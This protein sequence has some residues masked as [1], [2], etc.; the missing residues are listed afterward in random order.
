MQR[1]RFGFG[2]AMVGV[3]LVMALLPSTA[4]QAAEPPKITE[5]V[6]TVGVDTLRGATVTGDRA[7]KSNHEQQG[8][9][10]GYLRESASHGRLLDTRAVKTAH[11]PDPV[12]P[13]RFVDL[14]WDGNSEPAAVRA[15][16]AR[17]GTVGE[18]KR[19]RVDFQPAAQTVSP[20]R[21]RRLALLGA[22]S[23][24]DV[25]NSAAGLRL[26][27]SGYGTFYFSPGYATADTNNDGVADSSQMNSSFEDWE[28][29]GSPYF[30]YNRFG[31]WKPA[32]PANCS[33]YTYCVHVGT[34]DF[35]ILSRPWSGYRANFKKMWQVTPAATA[36]TCD[37][38]ANFS[39]SAGGFTLGIPVHR[40]NTTWTHEDYTAMQFGLDWDGHTAEKLR[41]DAAA[42][43]EAINSWVPLYWADQTY[44]AVDWCDWAM[45]D[46]CSY[47]FWNSY[48]FQDSGW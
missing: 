2:T 38:I 44:A 22:G 5:T 6:A 3:G 23:A 29:D 43:F 13:S 26:N 28:R 19:V 16:A 4:A 10:Q 7:D 21:E 17:M 35:S 34:N 18:H 11:V 46:F 24:F 48:K 8:R 39:V 12:S 14:V 41:L 47:T 42:S 36:T 1:A 15:Q 31:T 9:I 37:D 20:Q 25:A 33:L 30:F 32:E 45:P 40:C 27:D